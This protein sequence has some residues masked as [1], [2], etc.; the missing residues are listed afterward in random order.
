MKSSPRLA[1]QLRQ[2]SPRLSVSHP[3]LSTRRNY[4]KRPNLDGL[5]SFQPAGVNFLRTHRRCILADDMGLGKTAQS[6]RALAGPGFV[7]CP[8]SLID[9]WVTECR[10]WR[11]DIEPCTIRQASDIFTP[12]RNE[13]LIFSVDGL[14][15]PES[16]LDPRIIREN[17]SHCTLILD[18]AQKAKS[19][20]AQRSVLLDLLARECGRVWA[21]SGTPMIGTPED[22]WGVLVVTQLVE[23]TFGSRAGFE[24]AF[25]FANGRWPEIPPQLGLIRKLLARVML[26]RRIDKVLPSLA[27]V[28]RNQIWI[29]TPDDLVDRLAEVDDKWNAIGPRELPPFDLLA[30]L[31]KELAKSRIDPLLEYVRDCERAGETGLVLFGAHVDPLLEIADS[32]PG[33]RAITGNTPAE[34][35]FELVNRFQAGELRGLALSIGVGGTGF[36]LTRCNHAIFSSLSYTPGENDQTERRFLR[37]GQKSA[38]VR[39]TRFVTDHPVERRLLKILDAKTRRIRA[40]IDGQIAA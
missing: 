36:T 34:E 18:E 7:G 27:K 12:R 22:L 33:W 25:G 13:L 10:R 6:L 9:V 19:V 5:L 16:E 21:L 3:N 11:P 24:R 29:E 26:R 35:R 37:I 15:S 8:A 28:K 38:S 1:S 4:E 30:E 2:V 20:D 23:E 32:R 14:P 17:L 31:R 39:I 40:V